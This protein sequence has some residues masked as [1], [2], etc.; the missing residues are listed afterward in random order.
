MNMSGAQGLL[1]RL[2]LRL[3]EFDFKVED[4]PGSAHH[5]ADALSRLP[6][7]PSPRSLSIWK[8]QYWL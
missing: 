2:R 1:S 5:A 8:F 4:H 6:H 3:A 7:Q